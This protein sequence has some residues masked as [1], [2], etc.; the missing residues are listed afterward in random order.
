M[1]YS[2]APTRDPYKRLVNVDYYDGEIDHD[3]QVTKVNLTLPRFNKS[4]PLV[5]L[6]IKHSGGTSFVTTVKPVMKKLKGVFVSAKH[7]DWTKEKSAKNV[8]KSDIMLFLRHPV[9]RAISEF[10]YTKSYPWR[11]KRP[12][13]GQNLS[14]Y[15]SDYKEMLETRYIW[16]DGRAGVSWLTGTMLDKWAIG[17]RSQISDSEIEKREI[18]SLNIVRMCM[19]AAKRLRQTFWFGLLDDPER[20]LELLSF[21]LKYP[22]QIKM[23]N[24]NPGNYKR[25]HETVD[26]IDSGVREKIRKLMPVDMWLYQYSKL[27]FEARWGLFKTGH[28]LEPEIPAFPSFKCLSTRFVLKCNDMHYLLHSTDET[29]RKQLK[30]LPV[31]EKKVEAFK[32]SSV[33]P[34]TN[35]LDFYAY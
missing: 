8:P 9:D 15:L 20:S 1:K 32:D 30:L 18:L 19:R 27:L 23:R 22:G 33:E 28:Y 5:F 24:V 17:N 25:N 35:V 7:F 6:H 34:E 16:Q 2:Q 13:Q 26:S 21:Q 4:R 3:V 29:D 11:E 14:S 12:V 31:D 10:Y